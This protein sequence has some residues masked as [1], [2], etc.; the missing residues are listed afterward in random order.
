MHPKAVCLIEPDPKGDPNFATCYSRLNRAFTLMRKNTTRH[1]L[2]NLN[3][4]RQAP[5]SHDLASLIFKA[6]TRL[7]V[8]IYM[9]HVTTIVASA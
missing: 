4:N 1:V 7:V 5:L 2:A 6:A 3:Y 9:T 8:K